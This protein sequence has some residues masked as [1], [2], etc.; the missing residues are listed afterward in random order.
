M[1]MSRR[2]SFSKVVVVLARS[3]CPRKRACMLIFKGGGG[4]GKEL[5]PSKMS[6]FA[7]F[8]G[9]WWWSRQGQQAT[10]RK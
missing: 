5:P 6:A 1:K 2:G 7:C 8:R 3:N 4:G 9:Q 10:P